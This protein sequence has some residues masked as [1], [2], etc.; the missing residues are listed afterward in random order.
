MYRCSK[1]FPYHVKTFTKL[2]NSL[3]VGKTKCKEGDDKTNNNSLK[4]K[5]T[6]K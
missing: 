5:K 2:R 1:L 6:I 3:E 4:A